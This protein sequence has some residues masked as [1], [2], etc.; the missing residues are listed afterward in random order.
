MR[1]FCH[2]LHDTRWRNNVCIRVLWLFDFAQI[3]FQVPAHWYSCNWYT[4]I[5]LLVILISKSVALHPF[6]DVQVTRMPKF[7]LL[8]GKRTLRN[9]SWHRWK[10]IKYP[11]SYLDLHLQFALLL[12]VQIGAPKGNQLTPLPLRMSKLLECLNFELLQRN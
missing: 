12:E 3:C 11:S 6:N 5:I 7:E 4:F 9:K 8:Q 2:C 10:L 1:I